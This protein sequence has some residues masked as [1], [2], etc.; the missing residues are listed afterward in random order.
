MKKNTVEIV[1]DELTF[2]E[3]PAD[4]RELVD[5]AMAATDNSNAKYSG[6]HVGAAIRLADG[7]VMIGANQENA[8][9]SLCICAERSAIFAAQANYPDQSINAIAIAARNADGFVPSPVT[10]CGSCRQVMVEMEDRYKNNMTVLL[11]GKDKV[12]RLKSAKD[13]LP[14]GFVD[15]NMR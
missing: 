1:Y 3:L 7:R 15:D 9:F 14:L 13:L 5:R 4:Q 10:P 2:D 11:C 6:F 8:A 12:F